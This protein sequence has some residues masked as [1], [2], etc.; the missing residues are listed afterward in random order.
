MGT[1]GEPHPVRFNS[2][3]IMPAAS[4]L[5][6]LISSVLMEREGWVRDVALNVLTNKTRTVRLQL[7][8]R[9]NVLAFLMDH[10]SLTD[11]NTPYWHGCSAGIPS[12][13]PTA[14]VTRPPWSPTDLVMKW[15]AMAFA[16]HQAFNH[17]LA[18]CAA[19]DVLSDAQKANQPRP[20]RP[21]GLTHGQLKIR[22]RIGTATDL[23]RAGRS[24]HFAS[25]NDPA[26]NRVVTGLLPYMRC[27]HR[28]CEACIAG[29]Q[30]RAAVNLTPVP[31]PA[32]KGDRVSVDFLG[33]FPRS[34]YG[35]NLSI[36]A[37]DACTGFA[38]VGAMPDKTS[39]T[40]IQF[41][42]DWIRNHGPVKQIF[43]DTDSTLLSEEF[44]NF[45]RPATKDH[46]GTV[47]NITAPDAHHQLGQVER[48]NRTLG[49]ATICNL[50]D[51]NLP[52]SFGFLTLAAAAYIRN[53]VTL[54]PAIPGR[55]VMTCHEA[56]T[57]ERPDAERHRR[58]G[59]LAW[60]HVDKAARLKFDPHA[61][62]GIFVGYAKRAW[63]VYFP[64]TGKM[65]NS[66]HVSFDE[67][68]PGC[69][70]LK[71]A[72]TADSYATREFIDGWL[73]VTPNPLSGQDGPG[74]PPEEPTR[75]DTDSDEDEGDGIPY[76]PPYALPTRKNYPRSC[77]TVVPKLHVPRSAYPVPPEPRGPG[78]MILP[79]ASAPVLGRRDPV[80]ASPVPPASP[81]APLPPANTATPPATT[82]TL[83]GSWADQSPPPPR[84]GPITPNGS[85][86]ASEHTTPVPAR[87]SGHR[88]LSPI[89]ERP[90]DLFSSPPAP[91][92]SPI[93]D[94]APATTPTDPAPAAPATRS[95]AGGAGILRQNREGPR[96]SARIAQLTS[97]T[98]PGSPPLPP[99]TRQDPPPD[100]PRGPTGI[101]VGGASPLDAPFRDG[102]YEPGPRPDTPAGS[103]TA[104]GS[105]LHATSTEPQGG[106]NG[107][108]EGMRPSATSY[109]YHYPRDSIVPK[110]ARAARNDPLLPGW[111]AAERVEHAAHI[112]RATWR[113]NPVAPST[114]DLLRL[115]TLKFVYSH[116]HEDPDDDLAITRLKGRL[117]YD[118]FF[119]IT[120]ENTFSA[121]AN[122][123]SLRFMVALSGQLGLY[124][125]QVDFVSAY[126]NARLS[127]VI[128]ARLPKE[129]RQYD[130]NG[131]ELTVRLLRAIY[132]C[133]QAGREWW[134]V[135]I[136]LLKKLG[137][138]QCAS[139]QCVY[140]REEAGPSR[141]PRPAND[142]SIHL[143][144]LGD[145]FTVVLT[146]VDDLPIFATSQQLCDDLVK[147]LAAH[148]ELDDRGEL[149][150]SH[151]IVG[152]RLKHTDEA[153]EVRMAGHI[154]KVVEAAGLLDCKE[155]G[156]PA[157][158]NQY[159]DPGLCP[160]VGSHDQA[161]A[162]GRTFRSLTMSC[163][164]IANQARPD[165]QQAA[166]ALTRVC[167][168]PHKDH[169]RF[170]NRLLAYLHW[171]RDD[172]HLRYPKS[173]TPL[174]RKEIFSLLR[175]VLMYTDASYADDR[176]SSRSTSGICIKLTE[177]GA[178]FD[179]VSKL[180]P[181]VATSTA[182]S[183][184]EALYKGCLRVLAFQELAMEL[185][186]GAGRAPVAGLNDNTA[187]IHLAEDRG[188][189]ARSNTRH[190]RV[191]TH[192]VRDA[193]AKDNV[194]LTYCP[195]SL[196]LADVLTKPL[197]PKEHNRFR[198][199]LMG[200]TDADIPLSSIW[201][202][203]SKNVRKAQAR[204][205][206]AQRR[207]D[208][209]ASMSVRGGVGMAIPDSTDMH[210]AASACTSRRARPSLFSM[211]IPLRR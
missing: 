155:V 170:L 39:G 88:S 29:K 191:Q 201:H 202:N 84:G 92:A 210:T 209:A 148:Y 100:S 166:T 122:T 16:E 162:N 61:R 45:I 176:A 192:R 141:G 43:T 134:L 63:I 116:K 26:V 114:R 8:D 137:F 160:A 188:T 143:T 65:V 7:T 62:P 28:N 186:L 204:H 57:G 177:D 173:T 185:H 52:T 23:I 200:H 151:S 184:Y 130:E 98:P 72:G 109:G 118:G 123:P 99:G 67:L 31:P 132:G 203:V 103:A 25:A 17:Q 180:Q 68:R 94:T 131:N 36:A 167:H 30:C 178:V 101:L 15:C 129:F 121:S 198:R 187:T 86:Q 126:L 51:A 168:N 91:L 171:T 159:C 24:M 169:W 139:D 194:S 18:A 95:R 146:N 153:I 71:D 174:T 60:V 40:A 2:A 22:H 120:E 44:Q 165:I 172:C 108:R 111:Q 58:F 179:W 10:R 76:I 21:V 13:L 81:P 19:H 207:S 115:A 199:C 80:P 73:R 41:W 55:D 183:E 164:Y 59:C 117:V 48:L 150:V 133:R 189:S 154:E 152:L 205:D 32:T 74:P 66:I 128:D 83:F 125:R 82:R 182:E 47:H 157:L 142:G 140:I 211:E 49:E 70:L 14:A 12:P 110:N 195:T 6:I 42:Q 77:K 3:W 124:T 56:H 104:Y 33:P 112:K 175:P 145:N 156:S 93:R 50:R 96:R 69:C 64:D 107:N 87:A 38:D 136:D 127:E 34:L 37:I 105:A 46:P 79:T 27:A 78:N 147:E 75:P 161:E 90:S 9:N 144:D 20:I 54:A 208:D 206:V 119:Q 113:T 193:V 89:S 1:D 97:D 5:H 11:P 138:K 163:F 158:A 181:N 106:T 4:W 149:G 35:I 190:I 85:W 197:G 135:L 196:M 102:T 53:R